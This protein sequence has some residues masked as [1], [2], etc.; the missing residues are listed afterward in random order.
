MAPEL[1][2]SSSYA[3]ANEEARRWL[4]NLLHCP[5]MAIVNNNFI[6]YLG[7]AELHKLNRD[8]EP[9]TS[10]EELFERG[11]AKIKVQ[12]ESSEDVVVHVLKAEAMLCAVQK[13]FVNDVMAHMPVS[14][15]GSV[16]PVHFSDSDFKRQ[17]LCVQKV[18]PIDN[19]AL[20]EVFE[21]KKK[22]LGSSALPQRMYQR[23]PGQFCSMLKVIGFQ[24]EF[25]PPDDPK[26]GEG[27]YF[28]GSVQRAVDLWGK[29][30]STDTH[31]DV[32]QYYV[33]AQVLTGNSTAGKRDLIMPPPIGN[34][35]LIR[36]DSLTG[37]SDITVIFNGHQ[38][39]PMCIFIC[40]NDNS[41]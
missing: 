31:Q 7:V 19:T 4:E 23:I 5:S 22:R 30:S 29:Q 28:A 26:F 27:I 15:R 12:A 10:I 6:Q 38:A 11:C 9:A 2:L 37:G 3:E 21:L 13:E 14:Q 33:E 35:P 24:R 40:K 1:R 39:L 41:H 16:S 20:T 32:Y 8:A 17:G 25:A 34:D 36:F 18:L